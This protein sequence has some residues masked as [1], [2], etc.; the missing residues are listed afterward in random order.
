MLKDIEEQR[1]SDFIKSLSTENDD[2]I[3]K[4]KEYAIKYDV[5]IIR[6][7]TRDFIRMILTIIKPKQILEIGTA[8]AYSTLV[9]HKT[10]KEACIVTIEDFDKRIIDA[11]NNI[12]KYFDQNKITLIEKDAGEYLK[13]CKEIDYYDFVFLDA[14]KGQYINW[15]KD[16]I[17]VTKNGGIIIADNIFKDGEILESKFL[18]KKRNRTIHKRM[19]DFLYQIKHDDCLNTYIFNIGDGISISIKK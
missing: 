15:L 1:I 9:M 12:S 10:V 17:R 3:I 13:E 14:A 4:L 11:K 2:E 7:E 16:I 5:P 8:I 19:R 6:D 18:I